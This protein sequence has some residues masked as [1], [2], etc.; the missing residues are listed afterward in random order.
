MFKNIVII[1][2]ALFKMTFTLTLS[3]IIALGLATIPYFLKKSKLFS[4]FIDFE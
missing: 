3:L 1:L 2:L 4:N